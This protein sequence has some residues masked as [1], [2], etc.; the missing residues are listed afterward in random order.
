VV[1]NKLKNWA[2]RELNCKKVIYLSN[3]TTIDNAINAETVLKGES[4]KRILC[5]ANLRD[6]KNHFLLLKIAVMLKQ[7][8]P[9]WT[10]TLGLCFVIFLVALLPPRT[11]FLHLFSSWYKI[12]KPTSKRWALQSYKLYAGYAYYFKPFT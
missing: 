11:K 1:N 6:P 9:D 4:G 2:E 7:S 8:N 10:G 3:F 12:K 5:L